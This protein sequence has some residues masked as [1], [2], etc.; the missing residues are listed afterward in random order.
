MRHLLDV[1]V[2]VALLAEEHV[3]HHLA[4]ELLSDESL[5]LA[6][7]PIVENMVLRIMN[8]PA[9]LGSTP[10]DFAGTRAA[11]RHVCSRR[12]SEWWADDV[13]LISSE[14]IVWEHVL[15]HRQVTDC[16][17]LAMAVEHGG[18][19]TTFD[20]RIPLQAVRGATVE[21]VRVL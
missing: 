10:T 15:G 12:D 2:W 18:V 17:L 5:Q 6:V 21:H 8:T 7:C 11:L 1:N 9:V 13:S 19:L 3:F 20:Q 16:Y 14:R 4:K